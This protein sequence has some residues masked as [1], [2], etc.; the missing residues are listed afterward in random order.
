MSNK[1]RVEKLRESL[2]EGYGAALVQ[3]DYNRAYLSSF[4]S[5]AGMLLVTP[6][7]AWLLVDF[8]Y[9][10]MACK[11]AKGVEVLLVDGSFYK[12]IDK[13]LGESGIKKI[14]LENQT[15]IAELNAVKAAL[16]GYEFDCSNTLS[17]VISKLRRI[18]D[19]EEIEKIK[20]AQAITD[21]AFAHIVTVIKPGMTER[22]VAA[23]LE[24]YMRKNGADALAF[25][26]IC[27][28][29]AKTS[30]PH[31]K[32]DDKVIQNGD[33]VTMDYG[34]LKNGYCSD[35]TRT[36]AVGGVS[37][38]QKRVYDIVL[39]AHLESMAAVHAGVR[40]DEIDKIARGII[41][42]EG[43][44]GCF[45]HGLGHS[46]GMEIHEDPRFSPSC[47]EVVEANTIM[48]IEPGI[49]IEGKFGV[50]IENMIVVRENG[51]EN[52]TNSPRELIIV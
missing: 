43:F 3:Y 40:G 52:L 33:F 13:L 32:P 37:E 12:M 2:P 17:N 24:Y 1:T 8:R 21:V 6:Q 20:A 23:E 41:Y 4:A 7:N 14:M 36:V 10:E 15:T 19:E 49:Y 45:G 18:K 51:Y 9:Y 22:E 47:K 25:E 48:T 5:S 46:V 28:S 27:V 44:E 29:G 11:G 50:R 34:A 31:G 30:L 39:R 38:E 16:P 35:M 42:G 26:T